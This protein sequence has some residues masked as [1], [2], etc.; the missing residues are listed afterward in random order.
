MSEIDIGAL[1]SIVDKQRADFIERLEKEIGPVT[2]AKLEDLREQYWI[3][4]KNAEALHNLYTKSAIVAIATDNYMGQ[5]G[6][7]EEIRNQANDLMQ[8]IDALV[9]AQNIRKNESDDRLMVANKAMFDQLSTENKTIGLD[10]LDSRY[11]KKEE[12]EEAMKAPL[13]EAYG[14]NLKRFK[15][16]AY[17][18]TTH[19]VGGK[20]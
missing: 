17:K 15:E 20:I 3:D 16:L 2:G 13:P 8:K 19:T 11:L 1:K 4:T 9:R 6:I 10:F 7:T 18:D 14:V 12:S 5:F